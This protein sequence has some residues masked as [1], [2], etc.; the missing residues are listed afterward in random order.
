MKTKIA[1]LGII[2]LVVIVL[3]LQNQQ[4]S[5]ERTDRLMELKAAIEAT[6][7]AQLM[8]D[9][10]SAT[11]NVS[12]FEKQEAGTEQEITSIAQ[13]RMLAS[14]AGDYTASEK[15]GEQETKL[16]LQ[17]I[18]VRES[19]AKWAWETQKLEDMLNDKT[20]WVVK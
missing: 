16:L 8:R 5:K 19:K 7:A 15:L 13:K 14:Q 20:N 3:A 6:P 2:V 11:N 10:V 4:E 17:L 12:L 18:S 1:I 9:Y